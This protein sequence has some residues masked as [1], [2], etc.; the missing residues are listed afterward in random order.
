MQLY[1]INILIS[2]LKKEIPKMH[3][4]RIL[5]IL[6]FILLSVIVKA[7]EVSVENYADEYFKYFAQFNASASNN[8]NTPYWLS[9]RRQGL[10]PI[11]AFWCH[12]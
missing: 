7:Q 1:E 12:I 5:I 2:Q 9:A 11:Y 4:Y 3:K 6:S 10:T 8:K